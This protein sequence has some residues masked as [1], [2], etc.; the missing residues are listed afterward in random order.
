MVV[1]TG[2]R[3]LKSHKLR[4]HNVWCEL[5]QA[6]AGPSSVTAGSL[7]ADGRQA[8]ACTI[9]LLR[10]RR[11]WIIFWAGFEAEQRRIAGERRARSPR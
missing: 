9:H 2:E 5:C 8:F 11:R 4:V 1:L 7:K 3:T 10:D 6:P